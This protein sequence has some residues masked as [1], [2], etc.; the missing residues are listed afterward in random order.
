MSSQESENL[1]KKE[2]QDQWMIP[3]CSITIFNIANIYVFGKMVTLGV[4]KMERKQ[5][6][7]WWMAPCSYNQRF[8]KHFDYMQYAIFGLMDYSQIYYYNFE[9]KQY[10]LVWKGGEEFTKCQGTRKMYLTVD[11]YQRFH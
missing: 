1:A 4:Q 10:A 11:D 8:H 9:H 5:F 3:D 2:F 6:L 7:D